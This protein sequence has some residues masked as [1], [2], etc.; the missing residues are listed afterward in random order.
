MI[1]IRKLTV[2][3]VIL[4]AAVIFATGTA[5]VIQ[6]QDSDSWDG[7]VADLT[8][9]NVRN[10]V[11]TLRF[12]IR[13]TGSDSPRIEFLY[14]D[15]YIVDESNQK[16]YFLLKDSEGQF[17]GGPK[18]KDWEGGRFSYIVEADGSKGLWIKFPVPVD[19]PDT[20]SISIPGFFPFEEVSL[21]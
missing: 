20:I 7:I 2:G 15:C 21:K 14:R 1:N 3:I 11:L 6:T 12:K 5:D 19:N 10:D 16:K 18:D 13:N 9:I 17:I 8:Q 4:T